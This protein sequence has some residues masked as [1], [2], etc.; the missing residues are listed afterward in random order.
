M[1]GSQQQIEAT[2]DALIAKLNADLPAKLEEINAETADDWQLEPPAGITFGPR[3]EI[4]YP[5]IMV[6]PES[7]EKELESAGSLYYEHAITVCV[8]LADGDE[9]TLLRKLL[10]YQRAVREVALRFRRPGDSPVS[11]D[12]GGYALEYVRDV[13]G[14]VMSETDE[15]GNPEG[16]IIS[17]ARTTFSVKQQQDI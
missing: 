8:W 6:L 2:I 1:P 14:P 16:A 15:E 11:T 7:M 17:W 3:S 10:R 12:P 9:E 5:W 13:Y 4:P